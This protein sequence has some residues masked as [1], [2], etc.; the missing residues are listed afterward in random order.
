MNGCCSSKNKKVIRFLIFRKIGFL[1]FAI[2]KKCS[3]N[4]ETGSSDQ[5]VVSVKLGAFL[6][7]N[8]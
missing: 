6:K 8:L 2:L 7:T 4:F 1:N 3:P 5:K